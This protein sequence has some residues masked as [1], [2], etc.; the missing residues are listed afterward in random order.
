[1]FDRP[2]GSPILDDRKKSGLGL[3]EVE[4]G[5]WGGF[6]FIR[7]RSGAE[8]LEQHLGALPGLVAP[9]RPADM[10]CTRR[11]TFDIRSNWKL[12]FENFNEI[13]HIPSL[14]GGTI[15]RQKRTWEPQ[16]Q[17][18]GNFVSMWARHEGS[19]LIIPGDPGFPAMPHLEGEHRHGTFYCSI[20]PA[21]LFAFCNDGMF[22]VRIEPLAPDRSRLSIGS[23]F[24]RA[25]VARPD[26]A[27]VAESYYRRVDK[28]TPEDFVA[29]DLQQ[30]GLASP[31]ASPGLL[32]RWEVFGPPFERW[33]LERVA[34]TNLTD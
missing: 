29:T 9:Y 25:T 13:Y 24:P 28:V 20:F 15:N 14:H 19:R 30:L 10:V 2:D 12:Y 3:I 6:I 31:F 27:E 16:P 22:F 33:V 18:P 26:F 17:A 32:C 4:S 34:G 8:T 7:L 21:T 1:M 23:C 5:A 11:K